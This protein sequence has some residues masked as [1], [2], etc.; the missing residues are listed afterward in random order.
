ME[1]FR[2]NREKIF[3]EIKDWTDPQDNIRLAT[4]VKKLSYKQWFYLH[5]SAYLLISYGINAIAF[6]TFGLLLFYS[7]YN[8]LFFVVCIAG[9]FIFLNFLAL[10]KKYKQR[11]LT[12]NINFYDL[13]MRDDF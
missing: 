6:I 12:K 13:W 4:N 3:P 9:I 1:Y 5:P 8:D 10:I 11:E 7:L 2:K